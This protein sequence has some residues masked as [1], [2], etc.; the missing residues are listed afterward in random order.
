MKEFKLPSLEELLKKGV[1]FGHKTN[2]RHPKMSPFIF[3]KRNGIS[4]IDLEK[5]VV[6][7]KKALDFTT[8]IAEK[9]GKI[10]FIG[11][12]K[13]AKEIVKK[14]ADSSAM[15]YI[16]GRWLGGTFTNFNNIVRLTQKLEKLEKDKEEGNWEKYT[17]K[18]QVTF[19][20]Q[21][22]K[23][24]DTVGGIRTMKQLPAAVFVVD[25]KKEKTAV[26]EANKMKVPV[27]AMTDT[28]VN[29]EMV[30]YPIPANDDAIKSIEVITNLIAEAINNSKK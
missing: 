27:I 14:A 2:K 4:V 3:T 8:K 6:Y 25:I 12:K 9:D 26:L 21:I 22:A 20:K 30:Q 29:P 17:K 11:S 15:P 28:N 1:H 13:Q 5:T 10:L 7:L 23:L 19:T 16:I 24:E 18:E